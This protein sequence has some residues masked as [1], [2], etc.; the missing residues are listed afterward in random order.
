[1]VEIPC[2]KVGDFFVGTSTGSVPRQAQAPQQDFR[3]RHSRKGMHCNR[4]GIAPR[5]FHPRMGM[6]RGMFV[7]THTPFFRFHQF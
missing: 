7:L 2:R 1:M 5:P 3:A 4:I 6:H